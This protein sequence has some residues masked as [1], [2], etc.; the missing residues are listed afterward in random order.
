MTS[1]SA[2]PAQPART[3]SGD[4]VSAGLLWWA[5]LA[6]L[7]AVL[8]APLLVVDVPPLLDYPNHLARAFV[9]ASLPRDT[10]LAR[11]YAPHWSIIPNLALDLVAPP[12]IHV[13]P[14][15]VVGR[16]LIAAAVLL[17]VLGTVAY[18]AALTRLPS[19]RW[20]SLGVGLM[21]YN[22]CLLYGFLN[23]L[24]SIGLALLLAATWLSL[25]RGSPAASDPAG[26]VRGAGP[27]CLP[28]DGLAVLRRAGRISGAGQALPAA[29]RR[30]RSRHDTARR[31]AG[32]D[33]RRARHALCDFGI[34][35]A[36]W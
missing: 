19:G 7:C 11:F 23:F 4:L 12:L 30:S 13:L 5:A 18:N 22:N 36:W 32:A 27:V 33:L 26:D 25:A 16:L 3:R 35:T 28:P 34:A 15:H 21:A 1:L 10:I 9:L 2:A 8:L 20:W 24:I 31:R 17:P 14:V 6:G 29:G